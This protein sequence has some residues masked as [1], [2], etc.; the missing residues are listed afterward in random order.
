MRTH[1]K[2]VALA[3]G[4]ALLLE[5]VNPTAYTQYGPGPPCSIISV[6]IAGPVQGNVGASLK[7]T[8]E[9]KTEGCSPSGYKWTLKAAPQGAAAWS[10]TGQDVS[11]TPNVA[12]DYVLQLEVSAQG[13]NGPPITGT[14]EHK[15]TVKA[16]GSQPSGVQEF[17][18][19]LAP[20]SDGQL[21]TFPAK[22]T[23]SA[24][25]VRLFL[26]SLERGVTLV[27]RREGVQAGA[28]TVLVE[29]GKL[30]TVEVEL[31]QGM[32]NMIDQSSNTQLGQ[33]EAR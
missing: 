10:A 23:I 9:A 4:L 11:F 33:I 32:Y 2:V 29:P 13:T 6:T 17:A 1:G 19:I 21:R 26:T 8:G 31:A 24:G 16:Q 28:A 5:G 12:G 3:V 22:L 25:A 15:L 30:V 20:G 7:F 27:I 14:A 18:L